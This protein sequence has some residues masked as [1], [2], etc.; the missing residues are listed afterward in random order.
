MIQVTYN[1]ES[2]IKL[3]KCS[4]KFIEKIEGSPLITLVGTSLHLNDS[5]YLIYV[6]RCRGGLLC[7]GA[8]C[9]GGTRRAHS[10]FS[11]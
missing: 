5:Y 1:W 9:K 7:L 3:N 8:Y 2:F 10:G 11:L 6:I 4:T